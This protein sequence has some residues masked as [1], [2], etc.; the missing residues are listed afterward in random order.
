LLVKRNAGGITTAVN[1][2]PEH[3]DQIIAQIAAFFGNKSCYSAHDV[4]LLGLGL[5][6]LTPARCMLAFRA[7]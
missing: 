2:L 7:A 6:R 3:I 5:K 1:Q 4:P